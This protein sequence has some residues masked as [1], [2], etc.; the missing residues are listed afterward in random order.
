MDNEIHYLTYD[1]DA[2]WMEMMAA[3]LEAGGDILYPGDEKEMILRAAL[4][5]AVN[6]FAGVDNALRMATLRYAAGEYLSMI[7]ENRLCE[8]MEA[9]KATATVKITFAESGQ[10]RTYPAGTALTADGIRIW[11]LTETVEQSGYAQ[12][13]TAGIEAQ[14]PGAAGNGLPAGTQMQFMTP[15]AAPVAIVTLTD[16]TGGQDQEDDESYRERIRRSG[17][18]RSTAGASV[19]YE[20]IAMAANPSVVDARAINVGA[21]VSGVYLLIE[22]GSDVPGVIADV[23]N[24]LNPTSARPLTDNVH[25]E[26]AVKHSY[27]LHIICTREEGS[28][29]AAA[30]DAAVEEYLIWQNRKLGRPF[31]PDRLVS[32]IYNAGAARV[33]I[34]AD[35]SYDGGT[36]EY[37]PVIAHE[38][39]AGEVEVTYE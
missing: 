5:T 14:T 39:C 26:Q 37:T 38:Y 25:V 36:A 16:A 28:D 18:L 32:M 35:S 10:A 17:L 15:M 9:T 4:A 27:S 20:S 11:L 30:V 29:I 22:D 6:L 7:G 1:P 24:A 13:I 31:N 19:A 3:V 23:K 34:A 33:V 8:R 21:G 2:I 12:T